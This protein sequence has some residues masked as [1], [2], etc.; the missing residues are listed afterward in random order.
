[1]YESPNLLE[2][3]LTQD[4]VRDEA[5]NPILPRLTQSRVSKWK[6]STDGWTLRGLEEKQIGNTLRLTRIKILRHDMYLNLN[7]I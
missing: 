7:R 3:R 2:P 4:P 6:L 1:M 5:W